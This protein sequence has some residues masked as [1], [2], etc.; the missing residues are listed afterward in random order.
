MKTKNIVL[1]GM[2]GC[3]KT[4][5]G[6][7]LSKEIEYDF[8]DCDE[9]IQN[10]SN[11]TISQLFEEGEDVFRNWEAKACI[12]LS[13]KQKCIISTGGG[14]IKK[15][16]NIKFLKETGIIFFINRPVN[17]IKKD[18]DIDSRP[19]LSKDPTIIYQI[20]IERYPM[21][22][23]AAD[24]NIPNAGDL[25]SVVSAIKEVISNA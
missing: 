18:I 2:S 14:V 5:I 15:P 11:K 8:Y 6:Q 23:A 12:D 7:E 16:E 1:I 24:Y 25:L 17:H 22:T 13:K 9:Y 4:T 10:I 19:L 3:G 20:F 21:Y